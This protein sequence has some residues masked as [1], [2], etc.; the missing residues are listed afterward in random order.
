MKFRGSK[1]NSK[2]KPKII[3]DSF[4]RYSKWNRSSRE[5]P[6]ILEFTENIE[7]VEGNEFGMVLHILG[8]RGIHLEYCIKHPPFTDK[9]GN[10]EPDFT[11]EYVVKSNDNKFYI[12]DSIWLP[13]EDK[14][15]IWEVIVR[16]N[17]EIIASK[18]FNVY[19]EVSCF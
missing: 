12:G 17:A 1:K 9:Y 16:H 5:L 6:K 4:G 15:G 7:S 13:V 11:G 8:G 18:K 14:V 3:I 10:P 2:R 19:L